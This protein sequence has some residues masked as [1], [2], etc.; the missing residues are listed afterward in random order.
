MKMH[1]KAI[2]A[3]IGSAAMFGLIVGAVTESTSAQADS[4]NSIGGAGAT[5]VQETGG[6][7]APLTAVVITATPGTKSTPACGFGMV[8]TCGLP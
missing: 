7:A 2:G 1:S 3:T 4:S 8:Y 5:M 6:K